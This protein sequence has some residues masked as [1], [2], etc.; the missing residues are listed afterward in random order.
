MRSHQWLAAALE[1]VHM[2]KRLELIVVP[3]ADIDRAKP[4]CR[5][6]CF[7]DPHTAGSFSRI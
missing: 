6:L 1:E 3:L 7:R 4:L 5:S 2:D